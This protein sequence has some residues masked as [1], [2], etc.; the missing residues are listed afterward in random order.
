MVS[1][2]TELSDAMR[3]FSRA[4]DWEKYHDPKSLALALVGEVGELAELYQWDDGEEVPRHRVAEE[5]A[6][7]AIYLLRLADVAGVDIEKAVDDKIRA[8]A[9]R[10]PADRWKGRAGRADN[11]TDGR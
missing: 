5:I 1:D 6:D 4:R 10:Y 11:T 3:R 7:V 2:L 9:D 8:N